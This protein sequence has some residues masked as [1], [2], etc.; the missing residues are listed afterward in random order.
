MPQPNSSDSV[1]QRVRQLIT[2]LLKFA[3][4]QL[5]GYEHLADKITVRWSENGRCLPKLVVKTQIR[6]LAELA[7]NHQDTKTK[8]DL[9][10]ALHTLRDFLGILEDNRART[11]GSAVWHFTL[12]LWHQSSV[13]INLTKLN[14]AWSDRKQGRQRETSSD[15]GNIPAIAID[16]F[17]TTNLQANDS[18]QRNELSSDALIFHN[19]PAQDYGYF[20]GREVVTKRLWHLLTSDQAPARI[21]IKGIGGV[22]KTSLALHIAHQV[23]KN[24]TS[25]QS[26]AV[27]SSF[28][29][30]IFASA[31]RY[32]FSTCGI[33][34]RYRS[35]QTLLEIFRAIAQTLKRPE[36]MMG[37][38][39]E[40]FIRVQ[41]LLNQQKTLLI[42]DNLETIQPAS[43]AKVLSFLYDLPSTTRVL[44]T[45]RDHLSLDTLIQL[46]PLDIAEGLEFIQHHAQ[47]KSIELSSV[48]HHYLFEQTGGVPAAIVYAI[49]LLADG[50]PLAS[51]I[52]KLTMA[53]GD[54]CRY[55]LANAVMSLKDHSAHQLLMALALFPQ[56]ALREAVAQVGLGIQDEIEGFAK[57]Q[58][59]SLVVIQQGRYSLLPSTREYALAELKADPE[60]ER[61]A[62]GRWITWALELLRQFTNPH[63][64]EWNDHGQIH[65]EWGNLQ[66]VVE[67]CIEQNHYDHFGEFWPLVKGYTHIHGYWHE[68]LTWLTWWVEAAQARQDH[69]V[70]L[71][72]LRDKGWTLLLMGHPE[73]L[74]GAETCF[75]QIWP[76]RSNA[77]LVFQLEFAIEYA[78][79]SL[80]QK[81][82][83]RADDQ[84]NNA[85]IVLDRLEQSEPTAYRKEGIRINYYG[86]EIAYRQGNF[87]QAKER[88]QN[89]LA[90]ARA[91]QWTQVEVYTLNWLADIALHQRQLDEVSALLEVSLPLAK[92]YQDRRSQAF[93][94]KT[95]ARLEQ[96][97]GNLSQFQEK[98]ASAITAFENLGM[99]AEV[100]EIQTWLAE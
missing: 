90:Q 14:E 1:K 83:E 95:Q 81:R 50:Y 36:L 48:E 87:D 56:P 70:V 15:T 89:V 97:R 86:A 53:T 49:G 37:N 58:Q 55:Y 76:K 20:I 84:L 75:E 77:D 72:A 23:L 100:D 40:Q 24:E 68:R 74:A 26:G 3:N 35:E 71:Q 67:W 2:K 63:W 93:H 17:V 34:E 13:E 61:A 69:G 25:S 33:L 46:N 52:P 29:A 21:S 60:F 66:A 79:L 11:Q 65:G 32:R 43:K 18:S 91:I 99:Q 19:L 7:F 64:R 8:D 4:H 94:Q 16:S 80:Q 42:L 98:A 12:S 31:Q 5:D 96:L 88:Y 10:Q 73:Q 47:L 44:V 6:F 38:I 45:S 9:K 78:V 82:F 27:D 85:K 92:R 59:R 30:I 22:G 28:K 51:V 54:Y 41:S 39:S 62:R 57:L